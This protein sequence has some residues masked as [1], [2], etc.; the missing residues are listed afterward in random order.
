MCLLLLLCYIYTLKLPFEGCFLMILQ[1]NP[2]YTVF[3][4][5]EPWNHLFPWRNVSVQYQKRM[6]LK[7]YVL[8]FFHTQ[9]SVCKQLTCFFYKQNICIPRNHT[10]QL[11]LNNDKKSQEISAFSYSESSLLCVC[12][13]LDLNGKLLTFPPWN[14]KWDKPVR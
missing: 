14:I 10:F 8:I 13:L 7:L 12:L 6:Q 11:I 1:E 9:T 2:T 4:F 5:E 3:F